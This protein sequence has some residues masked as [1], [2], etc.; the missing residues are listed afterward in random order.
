MESYSVHNVV[1]AVF[2]F[3]V[4]SLTLS[5]ISNNSGLLIQSNRY[6]K[7]PVWTTLC[8]IGSRGSSTKSPCITVT[9]ATSVFV[10]A[11]HSFTLLDF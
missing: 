1:N 8:T 5:V 7:I 10:V 11:S 3:K 4:V 9:I 6:D 2:G